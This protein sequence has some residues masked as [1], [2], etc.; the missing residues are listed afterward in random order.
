MREQQT[1]C[2]VWALVMVPPLYLTWEI[3]TGGRAWLYGFALATTVACA[4][5]WLSPAGFPRLQPLLRIP[6]LLRFAGFFL[7]RSLAGGMDVAWRAVHPRMPLT[8]HWVDYPLQLT[9]DSARA[10]FLGALSLTPGTLAVDLQGNTVR[11]HAIISKVE[12]DLKALEQHV[13]DIFGQSLEFRP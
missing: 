3:L 2:L 8:P 13:A 1:T 6:A 10:L 12:P 11:V 7:R 4:S 9:G 5:A